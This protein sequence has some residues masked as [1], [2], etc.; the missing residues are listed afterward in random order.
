MATH[1][2]RKLIAATDFVTNKGGQEEKEY[3]EVKPN[4]AK[5][6]VHAKMKRN[7]AQKLV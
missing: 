5:I 1:A 4:L 3:A 6:G 2:Q 7:V